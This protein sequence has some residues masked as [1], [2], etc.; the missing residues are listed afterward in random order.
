MLEERG[1]EGERLLDTP[2]AIAHHRFDGF[3]NG[4]VTHCRV[5]LGGVIQG[6]TD[7]ECVEHASDKAELIQT[8]TMV[9]GVVRHQHLL[10]W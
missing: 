7:A 9:G 8:L 10:Y 3:P 1:N 5:L 4:Q 6:V 2:Q